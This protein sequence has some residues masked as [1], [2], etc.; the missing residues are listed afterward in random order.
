MSVQFP[1]RRYTDTAARRALLAR[2]LAGCNAIPGIQEAGAAVIVP[3]TGNN[4]TVPFERIE[5]PVPARERPP[6]VGIQ[7][8]SSGYFKVLGIPLRSGRLFD[9]RDAAGPMLSEAPDRERTSP[10]RIRLGRKS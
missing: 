4:W 6:E 5:K 8:A 2:V 3:L 7:T 1:A 10:T 9:Q